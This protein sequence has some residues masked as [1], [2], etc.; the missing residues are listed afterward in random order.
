MGSYKEN[1][2][3]IQGNVFF[4][5][6]F[7]VFLLCFSGNSDSTTSRSISY[8][9]HNEAVFGN[10]SKQ[11]CA[12]ECTA[13]RAPDPLA[14][15]PAGLQNTSLNLFSVQYYISGYNHKTTLDYINLQQKRL[16]IKPLLRRSFFYP[17]VLADKDSI[18]VLS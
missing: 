4:I 8:S 3:H 16:E 17:P 6:L 1:T 2:N 12:I 5:I 13:S 10:I 15:F 9:S 18:P 14:N 11:S 7:S